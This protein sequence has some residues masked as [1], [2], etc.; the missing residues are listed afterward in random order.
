METSEVEMPSQIDGFPVTEVGA[1]AFYYNFTV[2]KMILPEGLKKI[3]DSAFGN[4][5]NLNTIILPESLTSIEGYAFSSCSSLN[6]IYIPKN[7]NNIGTPT[8]EKA[9]FFLV[10][11]LNKF[12]PSDILALRSEKNLFILL[13]L[14]VK[15]NFF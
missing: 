6:S 13:T 10:L 7:V 12:I 15:E 9:V 11:T 4:N 5:R 2:T 8:L 1:Y 14:Q 3:N